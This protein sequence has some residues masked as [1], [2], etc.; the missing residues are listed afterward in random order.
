MIKYSLCPA[1]NRDGSWH[2]G[3]PAD[4]V[5]PELPEPCVGINF[6]RDGMPRKDWLSLVAVHSDTWLLSVAF[7]YAVKL[8]AAGRA[9]LFKIINSNAT[10]FETING[11]KGGAGGSGK[12]GEPALKK[13]KAVSAVH[14]CP[15]LQL[16]EQAS[17]E[18]VH[19]A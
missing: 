15:S 9:R 16:L 19:A 18:T 17:G 4:E 3:P 10:L 5:P 13:F 1:G 8:D 2:V 6:A 11:R 12:A 7:Y 14:A